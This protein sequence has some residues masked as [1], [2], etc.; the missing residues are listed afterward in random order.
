[1]MF[2]QVNRVLGIIYPMDVLYVIRRARDYGL[3]YH[4]NFADIQFSTDVCACKVENPPSQ[5]DEEREVNKQSDQ[6]LAEQHVF[7]I[8]KCL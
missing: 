3:E 1:M 7:W 5:S 2:L 6:T 8:S 4:L